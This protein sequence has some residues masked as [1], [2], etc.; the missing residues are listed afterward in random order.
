MSKLIIAG[1]VFGLVFFVFHLFFW[2]LFDWKNDLKKLT[3]LNR[4]VMQVLNICLTFVFL[5]FAVL[6]ILFSEEMLRPGLGKSLT[7]SIGLLWL[8]RASL[9]PL[10][11]EFKSTVSKAFFFV[12]LIGSALYLIPL[13]G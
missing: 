7:F 12:F 8:F 2:T 11:F 9:Q 13:F 3:G 1:G 6:S 4:G 5:V 10:F